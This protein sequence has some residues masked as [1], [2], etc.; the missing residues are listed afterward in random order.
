MVPREVSE[1]TI[2][3]EVGWRKAPKQ[4]NRQNKQ[5]D[6]IRSEGSSPRHLNSNRQK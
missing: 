6:V 5:V 1:V 2:D 3:C 4:A